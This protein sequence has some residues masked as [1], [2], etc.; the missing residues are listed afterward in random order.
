M[1]I[2]PLLVI[3]LVLLIG[4]LVSYFVPDGRMKNLA[5]VITAVVTLVVLIFWLLHVFGVLRGPVGL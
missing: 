3:L 2:H 4:G 1:N 5:Y